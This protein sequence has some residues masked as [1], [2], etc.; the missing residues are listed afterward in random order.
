MV[1]LFT[2]LNIRGMRIF[3]KKVIHRGDN[4]P[5]LVRYSI[6]SCRWFAIKVH[7]ILISD[8]DCLHDHPWSFISIL[9]RGSYQ[10][11]SSIYGKQHYAHFPKKYSAGDVLYRKAD[12]AHKLVLEPGKTVWTLVITFKKE[13]EWGFFT[14]DGWVK[15]FKYRGGECG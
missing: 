1:Q 11:V 6:F 8:D 13:R 14:K 15:W 4:I 9:L 5:Y 7:H 3:K 10:E 2:Q 12:W